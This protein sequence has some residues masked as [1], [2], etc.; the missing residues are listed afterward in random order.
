MT[1]QLDAL[2]GV[3]YRGHEILETVYLIQ[4]ESVLN[5]YAVPGIAYWVTGRL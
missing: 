3:K 5:R 2:Q 1:S 4:H